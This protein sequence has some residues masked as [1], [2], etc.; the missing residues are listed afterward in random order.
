MYH[1]YSAL[2]RLFTSC[3][4]RSLQRN[5]QGPNAASIFCP[6]GQSDLKLPATVMRLLDCQVLAG[7]AS[8][9]DINLHF[10]SPV[11]TL[12]LHPLLH[13]TLHH[14]CTSI[15]PYV[16]FCLYSNRR[17]DVGG[18]YTRSHNKLGKCCIF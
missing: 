17:P 14:H 3:T 12:H 5:V 15:H 9:L 18:V 8:R 2:N 6:P 16:S 7:S 4:A 10:V 13:N 1:Q 11:I